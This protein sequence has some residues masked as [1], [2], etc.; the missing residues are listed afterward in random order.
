M[1]AAKAAS[2][3]AFLFF[4][5]S[6]HTALVDRV[7]LESDLRRAVEQREFWVAYQ[8]IVDLETREVTGME[9]LARWKHPLKGTINPDDFIPVAEET[10][11][12][13]AIGRMVMMEACRRGAKWNRRRSAE[14][15]LSVTVNLSAKQLQSPELV[16]DVQHVLEQTGLPAG[17]LI[18]EITESVIMHHSEITLDRLRALKEVG[19]RLAIDDFGTGYSS[20]S[21]LQQFPVD[22]LKIDRSFTNGLNRGPNEDALARTIIALGDLLTLRTIAEG[23]ELEGQHD[24]LRDLGCDYGQGFLFGRPIS[25]EEMTRVLEV[26]P[27]GMSMLTED[28][29]TEVEL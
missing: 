16:R 1:Y 18:L 21:Y 3:G 28:E 17:C 14:K 19:V 27:Q 22:I 15:Q 13:I 2:R 20:L 10:G 12:I 25:A 6:M 4:D 7:M 8:P 11:M 26:S 9:A 29:K 5:P 23:V 24:R